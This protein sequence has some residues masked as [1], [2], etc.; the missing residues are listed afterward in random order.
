LNELQLVVEVVLEPEND[1]VEVVEVLDGVVT[2]PKTAADV[3]KIIPAF[4]GNE[5]RA[6]LAQ[7]RQ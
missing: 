6:L 4:V 2:L 5:S 7:L 3:G 1:F